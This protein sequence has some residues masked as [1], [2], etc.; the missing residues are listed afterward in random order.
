[1]EHRRFNVSSNTSKT[2]PAKLLAVFVVVEC[3]EPTIPFGH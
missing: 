3:R 2:K 1:M